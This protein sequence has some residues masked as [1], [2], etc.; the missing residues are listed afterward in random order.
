MAAS[1]YAELRV[2]VVDDFNSFRIT[3]NKILYDLEFRHIDSVGSGEEALVMCDQHHYDVILCDYNLG[4]GKNGQQLLEQLRLSN[5]L[6]P[7]DVFILLSAE[8]SRN[9]VMSAYDCEPDAY[10][11]KPITI[12]VIEQR[13][14]RLLNRRSVM[15]GIH[16]SI[17]LNDI[18]TAVELMKKEISANTR[19]SMDCQK[20]LAEVYINNDRLDE[21]E[22]VYRTVLEMRALDWAQVGLAKVKIAQGDPAKAAEW[23]N[24]IIK[25]NPSCMR[26]YD[27]LA[28]ALEALDDRESLQKI[29]EKAVEVSPMSIGRQAVLAKT[30]L[31]NGDAEV[32]AKAYRK[33]VKHG[34]NSCHDTVENQMNFAKAVARF[35]D[36]DA[37][38]AADMA[39]EAIGVLKQMDEN[40]EVDEDLQVKSQLLGSQLW[41]IQGEDKKSDAMLD[42]V[43]DSL[44]EKA[45]VDIDVEIEIV[46]TL[47]A[48]NNMKQAQKKI[49]E[50]IDQ[51]QHDEIALAK[52]DPLLAEPV[53]EEG[54]NLL[55]IANKKGIEAYK[56]MEYDNAIEFFNQMEKRYPR[57][58]GVKLNLAQAIIGK[59]RSRGP[60]EELIN[61]CLTIFDVVQRYI[62]AENPQYNRY[63]QLQ[64]M[65]RTVTSIKPENS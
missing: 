15:L 39:K 26:A 61:R 22:T 46:N 14:N 6:K 40:H 1:P 58:I 50:L 49:K 62:N 24:D 5:L 19:N 28:S 4:K 55:A 53:S 31:E 51:Y 16:R 38:K 63:R 48:K 33:T 56:N 37:V 9:V 29:M 65:L 44:R 43:T 13:L 25:N 7:Q 57:Y 20:A 32:A 36:K 10:L 8:T 30:A 2:L 60:D 21:A 42:E 23:L 17:A 34:A 3:L 12:K 59:I 11:T 18:D 35:Y 41:A 45:Y 64:D 54:K 27:V 52:I 47:I